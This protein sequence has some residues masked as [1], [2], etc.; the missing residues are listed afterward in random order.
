MPLVEQKEYFREYDKKRDKT[1][2]RIKYKKEYNKI[3]RRNNSDEL[4]LYI[5]EWRKRHPDYNKS[6]VRKEYARNYKQSEKYKKYLYSDEVKK[7]YNI[8]RRNRKSTDPQYKLSI[9]LRERFRQAMKKNYTGS[10]A[11]RD[12]GCSIDDFR[13]YLESLWQNGMTWENW[14]REGW[15]IDHKL[16]LSSFNLQDTEECLK[17]LHYTNLQPLWAKDNLRKGSLVL[18]T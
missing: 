14:N 2:E 7:R 18:N 9:N 15:H 12:L 4:N 11:I 8:Y 17:A 1:P 13:V 10:S 3:Y 6:K 16:P 5:R